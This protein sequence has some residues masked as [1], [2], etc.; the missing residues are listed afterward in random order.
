MPRRSV[1]GAL[2]EERGT[3]GQKAGWRAQLWLPSDDGMEIVDVALEQ[4]F[5]VEILSTVSRRN[6]SFAFDQLDVAYRDRC[7]LPWRCA[8]EE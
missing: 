8:A 2:W 6:G 1:F 5:E 4:T 3:G 7:R